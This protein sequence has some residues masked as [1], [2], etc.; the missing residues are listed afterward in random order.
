[1]VGAGEME[2]K[3]TGYGVGGLVAS[4]LIGGEAG[5]RLVESGSDGGLVATTPGEDEGG[6]G[7][8]VTN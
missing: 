5:F 7:G 6:A 8:M 2:G 3:M 4:L 1:M